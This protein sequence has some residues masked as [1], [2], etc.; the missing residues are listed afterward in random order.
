MTFA[1][2]E[3]AVEGAERIDP[4]LRGHRRA[5]RAVAEEHFDSDTVLARFLEEAGIEP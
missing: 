2:L 4:G 3:E 1:D 5:A